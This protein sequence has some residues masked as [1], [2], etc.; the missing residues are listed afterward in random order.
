[1]GNG[2]SGQNKERRG[3]LLHKFAQKIF[4][5]TEIHWYK[6]ANVQTTQKSHGNFV[7]PI[8]VIVCLQFSGSSTDAQKSRHRVRFFK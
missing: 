1:M 2:G 4:A 3:A 7:N 6:G 5:L 8:S